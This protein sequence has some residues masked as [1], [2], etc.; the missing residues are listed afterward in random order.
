MP[1]IN[2]ECKFYTAPFMHLSRYLIVRGL[3]TP[4]EHSKIRQCI[5]TS[6]VIRDH[7]FSRDDGMGRSSRVCIW[8]YAA[9]DVLG[10]TAR[11]V[12]LMWKTRACVLTKSLINFP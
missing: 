3:F 10:V 12:V 11:F 1:V 9:D 2:S 6:D 7:S 5:E 4:S 8:N